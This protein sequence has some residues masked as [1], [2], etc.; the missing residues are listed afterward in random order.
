MQD[1]YPKKPARNEN[2]ISMLPINHTTIDMYQE[3]RMSW[4]SVSRQTRGIASRPVRCQIFE[5]AKP[6]Q[7]FVPHLRINGDILCCRFS[8]NSPDRIERATLLI[9][10]LTKN[11]I[12]ESDRH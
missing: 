11:L 3:A 12:Y 2:L 7:L 9:V 1:R 10:Y 6:C 4:R 5:S 8:Q